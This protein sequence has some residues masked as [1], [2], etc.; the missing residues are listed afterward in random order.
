M[1]IQQF[2]SRL[3]QLNLA[4]IFLKL[5]FSF[6]GI[7]V[8]DDI[9]GLLQLMASKNPNSEIAAKIV[10]EG[11]YDPCKTFPENDVFWTK[12]AACDPGLP[13]EY[14]GGSEIYFPKFW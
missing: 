11:G 4:I 5:F 1:I 13:Q 12:N 10:L 3:T 9:I 7:T 14:F 6:P 2:Q 8:E